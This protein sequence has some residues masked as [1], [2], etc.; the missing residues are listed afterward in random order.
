[1]HLRG[2]Y[3]PDDVAGAV[4]WAAD[5]LD[6]LERRKS[7]GTAAPC[8]LPELFAALAGRNGDFPITAFHEGLR[9]LHERRV[10]SLLPCTA[11]GGEMAQ[12]E[13]AVLVNGSVLYYVT[14]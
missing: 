2:P 8:P 6:Y 4:P 12:P 1:L 9:R 7:G 5:A 11:D 10:V 13:F 3:L 14:A